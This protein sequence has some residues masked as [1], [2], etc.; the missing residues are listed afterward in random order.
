M[1]A[2]RRAAVCLCLGC[3]LAL[4]ATG[5]DA[6]ASPSPMV[7][8]INEVRRTHGL[9]VLR[10]SPSLSRSSSRF[11]RLL[12]RGN[13]FAHG[14]RINASSRFSR[15]GEILAL[16]RG[17]K[18]RRTRTLSYWLGSSSHRAVLLSSSFRYIGAARVRG[19]FRE[20]KAVIWTVQFGS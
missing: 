9:S 14:A 20:R 10:Y 19:Y 15:L 5:S 3:A 4:A 12:M 8:K 6:N 18:L 16:T 2:L 1:S 11:T 7:D 13:R 17:W